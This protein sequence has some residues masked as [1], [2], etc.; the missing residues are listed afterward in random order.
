MNNVHQDFQKTANAEQGSLCTTKKKPPRY[1]TT[2]D[3]P[4][5]TI[6]LSIDDHEHLK[7]LAG[8]MAL[9]TYIRTKALGKTVPRKRDR[10]S[11]SVIDKQS[12]AQ[13]LG[14]L[15]QSRIAN[16]LNQLAYHA[17]VG[18]LVMDE[19]TNELIL[20]AYEHVLFL[21]NTLI[22]ALGMQT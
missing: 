17:N 3:C 10:S 19:E 18:S 11:T 7:R 13:M 21:R 5:V 16:N 22:A 8:D 14:F 6:R 12:L 1:K 4:R 2:R 9:A 20:E 15:G